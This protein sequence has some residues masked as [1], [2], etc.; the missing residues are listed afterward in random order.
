[1]SK[2]DCLC[3]SFIRLTTCFGHWGWPAV[4]E[5][6]RQPNKTDTKAVVF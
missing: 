3:I 2:H 5:T 6:C 4:A 1:M